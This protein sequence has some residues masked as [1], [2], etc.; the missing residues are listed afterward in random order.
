[1]SRQPSVC[2][3]GA[4]MSG[5]LMAIK[6]IK[7][8]HTDFRIFEKSGKV[9]GTWRENRYPGVACDVAS[10]YYCYDFEPNPDWSHRFSPGPEI[11][12]Y[13][14]RVAKKYNLDQYIQYHTEVTSAVFKDKQWEVT[15][16]DGQTRRF[17]IYVAATGPLNNRKY[18]DIK[19]LADFQGK[20]FH[21]ADWDDDYDLTGKRV[22]LIGSGSSG[23]QASWPIAQAA[24]SLSIFMRTPQW[25]IATPNPEYGTLAIALKHKI[26][27][28]GK[29]TRW[30]YA[31][32][33]EQFG[34]AALFPGLRRKYIFKACEHSLNKIKDEALREKVRPTDLP[35][36]R[37]MIMSP[38]Y[39][40]ALQLDNVDVIREGIEKITADGVLCKDGTL[41]QLDLIVLAT[42]FYPNAWNV[43]HIVG[44]HGKTIDEVWNTDKVHSYRSIT[45]PGFPNYFMLIGPNSP[46]TN[47]SLVDI[48][49]I[50]V[51]YIL[52]CMDKIEAGEFD[53][54]APTVE[55]AN[56]FNQEL[57]NSFDGTIWV[58][59]CN[60]WYLDDD[61]IPQT[62][63]WAPSRFIN[64]LSE[65]DMAHYETV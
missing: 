63:P 22:G 58:S 51:D 24:K 57:Q 33:G 64:D 12:Q 5:I 4:G 15:T 37:R 23:V 60:S 14:E 20:C 30:F 7:R 65:P 3:V 9:G 42:G 16:A 46:I 41:H 29:L 21:T 18:P 40:D 26:P 27:L 38:T 19:G 36:C 50:G 48:A 39:H 53:T 32:V 28:L 34:R 35:M 62:W 17:D 44:E 2:I 8:G 59:G 10:F 6:L 45:L 13:F 56:A 31:W 55:A 61:G 25:V 52:K 1:M 49:S 11:Q 43:K 54:L 47:L